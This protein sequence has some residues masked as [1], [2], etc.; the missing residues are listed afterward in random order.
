MPT[1]AGNATS[2]LDDESNDP[3]ALF[4][5]S[6]GADTVR[7]PYPEWAE[8]LAKAPVR[9]LGTSEIPGADALEAAGHD[10]PVVY[11]ALSHDAVSQV[12]RNGKVFSSSA[13]AAA[14]GVVM[15]P[16]ILVM[17]EP[18]HS[19]YRGLI[20]MAFS[21]RDLEHWRVDLVEPI[22]NGFIDEFADRGRADLVRDLTFPFPVHVIAG[23]LG[24]PKEDLPD[25]HRWTI[26]LIAV[27]FDWELGIAASQRLAE[28]LTPIIHER[29]ER[30]GNDLISLLAQVKLDGLQLDDDH[31]LG[32]LRLLLPAGAE[33]TYRSS[34]NLLFGLLSNPDQLDAVRE[35]RS[36]IAQAM[37]EGLRWE[38][39]LTGIGRLCTTDTE[40]EGVMIP[41]GASVAVNLGAA[42]RDA[43][44]YEDP[45]RFDIHRPAKQHMA[46]AFGPHRCLGMNLA[47]METEVLFNR[48]FDRLPNLRLDP[49]A[50]D[51]HIT[52]RG[53]R[54]PRRLPVLFG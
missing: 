46:F 21:N 39:P 16:T 15:G 50:E 43:S 6:M 35:D 53:F 8:A 23:M 20:Q 52:G 49:E 14:M 29:R 12:L 9:R 54:S 31:I 28:Y 18:E 38:A 44:R 34:S 25:F 47:R 13:Y 40:V 36:L 45:T 19:R 24:L 30:P 26:A 32:F 37:E 17:D 1:E 27:S 5:R 48:I 22:I 3:F 11:E 51:V 4:D 42:N 10:V 7:D 33:T 2:P 41:A